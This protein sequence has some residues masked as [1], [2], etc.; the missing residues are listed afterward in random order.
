M[1]FFSQRRRNYALP[2][3]AVLACV[4]APPAMA[5]SAGGL[6]ATRAE[7]EQLLSTAPRQGD[8]NGRHL[9]DYMQPALIRQRLEEG[10]FQPGDEIHVEVE[11]FGDLSKT[12][13]VDPIRSII[14]PEIGAV[15]LRGVLRSE[16]QDYLTQT[17]A[18]YINN[19]VVRTQTTIR[20]VVLG[21]VGNPGY[22]LVPPHAQVTDVLALAGGTTRQAQITKMRVERGTGRERVLAGE[23]FHQAVI[24]GRTL[25]QLGIQAGDHFVIPER[26][27]QSQVR[28]VIG[29]V[30][31]VGGLV[32]LVIRIN[33]RR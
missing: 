32:Y 13:V 14:L 20:V 9:G 6:F 21:G 30:T 4:V 17:L 11:R 33:N 16:I 29:W 19:P 26:S 3:L 23:Q 27:T 7:L 31:T 1:R 10:D 28:N 18:R 24:A 12:Y 22:Y 8:A 5:Q 25:D 15:S 2:L